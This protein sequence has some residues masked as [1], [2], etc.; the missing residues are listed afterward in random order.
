M[1]V[2]VLLIWTW[3]LCLQ[4]L[5]RSVTFTSVHTIVCCLN[6][7]SLFVIYIYFSF[8]CFSHLIWFTDWCFSFSRSA[9]F[10]FGSF[11]TLYCIFSNLLLSL[12][13][14]QKKWAVRMTIFLVWAAQLGIFS[15]FSINLR[16]FFWFFFLAR[17][18]FTF[19]SIQCMS[20]NFALLNLYFS[21]IVLYHLF[22]LCFAFS[23]LNS[24]CKLATEFRKDFETKWSPN[25]SLY[26]KIASIS[27]FS[28]SLLIGCNWII[29]LFALWLMIF[30]IFR[31]Q[32]GIQCYCTAT[33][34][35][36]M[37]LN[38]IILS[39]KFTQWEIHWSFVQIT[40]TSLG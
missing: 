20:I 29:S 14:D 24:H 31:L 9:Y 4:W 13:Y 5:M 36:R 7:P 15:S 30:F 27:F 40:N 2:L 32:T 8:L 38:Q 33:N 25:F 11:W 16:R 39:L 1:S 17:R 12:M 21:R 34:F 23:L 10:L 3:W 6:K 18:W 22:F 26:I 28:F 37:L 35:D 19:S